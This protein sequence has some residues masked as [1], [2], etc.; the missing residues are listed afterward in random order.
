M[1]STALDSLLGIQRVYDDG[2]NPQTPKYVSIKGAVISYDA[3]NGWW[4]WDF[5]TGW[6][7]PSYG[8]AGTVAYSTGTAFAFAS[9][10]EIVSSATG[11]RADAYLAVGS[12]ALVAI[13][14]SVRLTASG[15]VKAY[16]SGSASLNLIS[17]A[18]GVVS[19]GETPYTSFMDLHSA[20]GVRVYAGGSNY[21]QLQTN[22][23]N[24]VS[25]VADCIVGADTVTSGAGKKLTIQGGSTSDAGQA[26][27]DVWITSGT[28]GTGG[29]AGSISLV[30]GAG[31]AMLVATPLSASE[32]LFSFGTASSQ[33]ATL[34]AGGDMDLDTG[35]GKDL[36][37]RT[38]GT[39]RAML[40]ASQFTTYG[41]RI[42]TTTRVTSTPWPVLATDDQ[43]YADTDSGDI[44]I[45]LPPGTD[46]QRFRIINCGSSGYSAIVVPSG[47]ELLNGVNLSETLS[48]GES[49]EITYET[50]EGWW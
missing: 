11:L 21:A 25:P 13:D 15:S 26:G 2:A 37:L 17:V 44:T 29:A 48:D 36:T 1:S 45:N 50:T 47:A 20:G 27:G 24:F 40:D 16:V 4:E 19:V 41:G 6:G 33:N 14:G 38:G 7:P 10:V 30:S 5:T 23:L 46:G 31:G 3:V 28:P 35:A 43:I 49:L 34:Q 22:Q 18:S 42:I 32:N 12:A 9:G 8:A 39:A